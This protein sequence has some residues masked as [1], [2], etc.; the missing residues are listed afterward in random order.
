MV[1][2]H[3]QQDKIAEHISAFV[4]DELRKIVT[5]PFFT[6]YFNPDAKTQKQKDT[7][8]KRAD[9][10]R[11]AREKQTDVLALKVLGAYASN[12]DE[13]LNW[14]ENDLGIFLAG[15]RVA[16]SKTGKARWDIIEKELTGGLPEKKYKERMRHLYDYMRL[17]M[18]KQQMHNF[19]LCTKV[20]MA[21]EVKL[22][23][24]CA[25]ESGPGKRMIW[26]YR[27]PLCSKITTN[28]MDGDDI[29][30]RVWVLRDLI[31]NTPGTDRK[32]TK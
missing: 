25:P 32:K 9:D 19:A 28:R 29:G 10:W 1:L 16:A 6:M 31:D 30:L 7:V 11:A 23:Y 4:L 5:D 27:D 24:R 14:L 22:F 17:R 18:T 12:S 3:K 26:N 21:G 13:P 20:R 15:Y 2:R 8:R